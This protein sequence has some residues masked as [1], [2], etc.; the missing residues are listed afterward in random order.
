MTDVAQLLMPAIRWDAKSGF[1]GHREAIDFAIERGVGGFIIFGGQRDAVRKLTD[2]LRERSKIPLLI[3]ADLERG[4][5]QQFAGC[6]GLPPLAAIAS[7]GDVDAI[8]GAAALTAREALSVGIN[9]VY[10]P[11][12]DLD[13]EPDN[14]IVGTRA[15]GSDP[16]TVATMAT[17]W[18]EACQAIGAL[19]C[20][21]HFPGHG[22][23]TVD[24][25]AA[26]PTVDVSA[27]T[28][29]ETDLVP[30]E[31]AVEKGVAAVMTAH[32][33]YPALDPSGM[34]ATLSRRILQE[35]LRGDL[36]FPGL[37]VTDA[38][39]MEGVLGGGEAVAVVRALAAGC[40]LLLYP[41]NLATCIDALQTALDSG[42]LDKNEIRLSIERRRHWADWANK[43]HRAAHIVADDE[44][45]AEQ[46]ADRAVHRV[47]GE[48]LNVAERMD[49]IVVD[50]DL[51]GPYPT[52]PRKPFVDKLNANGIAAEL[53]ETP[54]GNTDTGVIIALF[55]DIRSW[56]G[57]P[58]YSAGSLESVR[59]ALHA[60]SEA[61]QEAIIVQ[62]SHPR[63]AASIPEG[64]P[65]LCAWGGE[66]VMQR[67]AA[68]ILAGSKAAATTSR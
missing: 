43:E 34:P 9:W 61:K 32:V 27:E 6:I 68:R 30:F 51:G 31:A 39:I 25:H 49:V 42:E 17:N 1:D 24:S 58:G 33:A 67:A 52:P 63:L 65:I 15:L 10:A 37:I 60:A 20:A 28:L 57:R 46:L 47:R 18:I 55:G 2:E 11:V 59:K 41:T 8:R 22:R 54:S 23:T 45:W 44:V 36:G 62:F 14:P 50:D 21:K 48:S 29:A 12:C 3:G 53:R 19:A 38:L 7:L 13:I 66:S 5:G 16:K 4:A 56:K 26:L 64:A 35:T 40:D